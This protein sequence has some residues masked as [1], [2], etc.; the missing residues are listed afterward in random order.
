MQKKT[1]LVFK[2][3]TFIVFD[4]YKEELNNIIALCQNLLDNIKNESDKAK[5][6]KIMK[7]TE[8]ELKALDCLIAI[9]QTHCIE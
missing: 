7:D 8:K 5:I 6:F 2:K 9:M 4:L 3:S 1:F